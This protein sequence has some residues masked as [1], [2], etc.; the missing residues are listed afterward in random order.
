MFSVELNG[1][2]IRTLNDDQKITIVPWALT[3]I[4]DGSMDANKV[5]SQV[6]NIISNVN[7]FT[8]GTDNAGQRFLRVLVKSFQKKFPHHH[9]QVLNVQHMKI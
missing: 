2:I 4:D 6:V 1:V 9:Q 5:W 3:E 8:F 7:K